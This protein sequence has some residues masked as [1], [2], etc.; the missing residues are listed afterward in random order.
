MGSFFK[1]IPP[2][3]EFHHIEPHDGDMDTE[4]EANED[5]KAPDPPIWTEVAPIL[6]ILGYQYNKI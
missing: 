2:G 1:V 4:T 3:M 5:G 6:C